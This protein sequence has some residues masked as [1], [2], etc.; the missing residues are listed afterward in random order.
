MKITVIGAAG[1]LGSCAAFNIISQQMAQELV[2]LDVWKEM[3]NSHHIDFK[4]AVSGQNIKLMVGDYKDMADSDIVVMTAGAPSGKIASRK[5]LLPANIQI[6]KETAAYINRYCPDAIVI[7]ATNPVDPLNYAMYL[8]SSSRD[9]RKFIGYS[10]NDTYRFRNMAAAALGVPSHRVDGIVIGEHDLTQVALFSTLKLDGKPVS[11]DDDLKKKIREQQA[12]VLK[13]LEGMNPKRTTGWTSA[14]GMTAI[15]EAIINN[16]GETLPC[17]AI[18]E[19]EYG[20]QNLSTT[21]P[22]VLGKDG[23]RKIEQLSLTAE[24]KAGLEHSV[25]T[26]LPYMKLVEETLSAPENK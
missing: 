21:V 22:V 17:N 8:A 7:T 19:G 23:I 14:I 18:L 10:M 26:L 2:L 9:K 16:T 4:T 11:V 20:Y 25:Q 1:T 24:E 13:E 6:I 3:L 15:M 5:E 12:N